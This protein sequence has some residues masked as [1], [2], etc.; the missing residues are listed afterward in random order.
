MDQ[1]I[2]Q[3]EEVFAGMKR[4]RKGEDCLW[5]SFEG[6]PAKQEFDF[7]QMLL[8]DQKLKTSLNSHCNQNARSCAEFQGWDLK[9]EVPTSNW[10]LE[11]FWKVLY[12][13]KLHN[14]NCSN[15]GIT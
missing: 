5:S 6:F 15:N 14:N 3:M 10:N 4:G 2:L 9:H 12:A 8:R 11:I 7:F 13:E 1:A